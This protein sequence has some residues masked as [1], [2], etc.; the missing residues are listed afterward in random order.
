M[1]KAFFRYWLPILVWMTLIFIGSSDVLSAEHTSRVIEPLLRWLW[2]GISPAAIVK[3]HFL[4]RKA[5]H[6]S[7]YAVLA[8]LVY[9]AVVNTLLFRRP[10]ASAALVLGTC[11]I[12][13][14]SDEFHQSF[15]PSRTASVRDV[16]IDVSGA[17]L[18]VC[19]YS[20]VALGRTVPNEALRTSGPERI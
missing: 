8:V 5:G 14:A 17:L 6:V 12:Y 16:M 9:R 11:A 1:L 3:M 19:L 15:V 13:A 10:F 7:E 2:P 18:A 4:L 20:V